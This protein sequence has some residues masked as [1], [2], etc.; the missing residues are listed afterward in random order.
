[1][2]GRQGVVRPARIEV[3][4]DGLKGP[5]P[6]PCHRTSMRYR[7]LASDRTFSLLND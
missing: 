5:G 3:A 7:G 2:R 1:M 6:D 4:N